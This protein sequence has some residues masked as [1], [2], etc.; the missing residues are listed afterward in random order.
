[1]YAEKHNYEKIIGLNKKSC[2]FD[3]FSK[4]NIYL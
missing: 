2:Y 4:N 3:G 1:M